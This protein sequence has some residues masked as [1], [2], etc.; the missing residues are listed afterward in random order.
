MKIDFRLVVAAPSCRDR[1][2]GAPLRLVA[3]AGAMNW[4]RKGIDTAAARK[5]RACVFL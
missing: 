3:V 5:L 2:V 1:Q 4:L